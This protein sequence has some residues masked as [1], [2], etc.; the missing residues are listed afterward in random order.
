MAYLVRRNLPLLQGS[1]RRKPMTVFK[2]LAYLKL[3]PAFVRVYGHVAFVV[4]FIGL[5]LWNATQL[6][7]AFC[8]GHNKAW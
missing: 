5:H 6:L 8:R 1:H 2:V 7:H 3:D 4:V